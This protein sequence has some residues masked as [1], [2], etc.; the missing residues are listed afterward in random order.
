MKR[1]DTYKDS[2][3]EWIG[4]I[5][6]HWVKTKLKFNNQITSSNIDK[7]KHDGYFKH[8]IIHY[9]DVIGNKKINSSSKLGF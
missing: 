4:E 6:S 2:G 1:Y 3:V 9:N 5:P 7:K 8:Q